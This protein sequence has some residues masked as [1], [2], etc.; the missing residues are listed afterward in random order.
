VHSPTERDPTLPR[1]RP[2]TPAGPACPP[3]WSSAR[4]G[5]RAFCHGVSPIRA[6]C[7]GEPGP[8]EL[9]FAATPEAVSGRAHIPTT[10]C[11]S[12]SRPSCPSSSS[13]L[14]SSFPIL[15]PLPR[16]QQIPDLTL[17]DAGPAWVPQ[18]PSQLPGLLSPALSSIAGFLQQPRYLLISACCPGRC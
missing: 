13:Q 5:A 17:A 12:P 14:H 4:A 10:V 2:G 9:G 15:H 11:L 3:T 16:A 8:R 1:S 7:W 18:T 6:D